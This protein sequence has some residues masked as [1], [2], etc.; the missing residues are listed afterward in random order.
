MRCSARCPPR[1][2]RPGRTF[3][4][5]IASGAALLHR[6]CRRGDAGAVVSSAF[7]FDP[8]HAIWVVITTLVVM[9]PDDRNNYRRILERAAGTACRASSRP[10][11]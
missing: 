10:M 8:Q 2:C 1:P 3:R 11:C 7:G 9:Q 6:L 5:A 4:K